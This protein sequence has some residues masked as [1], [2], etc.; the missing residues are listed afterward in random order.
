M[1]PTKMTHVYLDSPSRELSNGGLGV[2][3]AL[4]VRWGIIFCV[5]IS[6]AQS[7]CRIQLH[8]PSVR[9]WNYII[10]TA[11]EVR[12]QSGDP[13]WIPQEKLHDAYYLTLL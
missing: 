8:S 5:R 10:T 6:D 11:V 12:F 4:L 7:S 1:D 9:H 13:F 3:V 2:V